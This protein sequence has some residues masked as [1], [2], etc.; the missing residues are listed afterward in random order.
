MGWEG[1]SVLAQSAWPSLNGATDCRWWKWSVAGKPGQVQDGWGWVLCFVFR[2]LRNPGLGMGGCRLQGPR[3]PAQG[4]CPP[5]CPVPQQS[6]GNRGC[7]LDAAAPCSLPRRHCRWPGSSCSVWPSSR[8]LPPPP[9]GP[10]SR[11]GALER[12]QL[13]GRESKAVKLWDLDPRA[14]TQMTPTSV[15]QPGQP[16]STPTGPR[17]LRK[18]SR[19][20]TMGAPP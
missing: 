3:D 14:P 18:P 17:R 20:Q 11:G 2:C 1:G 6:N 4:S 9:L 15:L 5:D 10:R 8:S 13:V 12:E 19:F 16:T 7:S